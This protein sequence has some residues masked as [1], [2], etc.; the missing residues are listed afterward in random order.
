MQKLMSFLGH[1]FLTFVL[2]MAAG[3]WPFRDLA[4]EVMNSELESVQFWAKRD[5]KV[6]EGGKGKRGA[7]AA[8]CIFEGGTTC[9][10]PLKSQNTPR[11]EFQ[12][13]LLFGHPLTKSAESF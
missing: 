6:Y 9:Q 7:A 11:C 5:G 13:S 2:L 8:R 4:K 12:M 1:L 10:Q 3:C